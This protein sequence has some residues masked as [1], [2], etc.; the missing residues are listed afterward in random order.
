MN[1][2]EKRKQLTKTLTFGLGKPLG[3][4][5]RGKVFVEPTED[6]RKA[7]YTSIRATSRLIAQM[8][9]MLNARE[10]IRRIMKIPE[11]VAKEFKGSYIP[12]KQELKI[13][14]VFQ[15]VNVK[16]LSETILRE[17]DPD[18]VSFYNINTHDDLA[19]AEYLTASTSV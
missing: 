5:T 11:S 12:I 3:W 18:L 8:V 9:N 13:R 14:K 17:N 16:K 7:I 6:Q 19:R 4:N 1:E 2:K 15:K 10:Y